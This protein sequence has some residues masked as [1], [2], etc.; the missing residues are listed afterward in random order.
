M[1]KSQPAD[2]CGAKSSSGLGH[3]CRFHDVRD[4]SRLPPG[5]ER[6]RQRSQPTL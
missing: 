4:E 1:E 2:R 5:P 6:Q 3:E